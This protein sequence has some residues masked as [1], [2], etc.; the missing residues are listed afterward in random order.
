VVEGGTVT[1]PDG[2][3]LDGITRQSAIDLLGELNVKLVKGD[4]CPARLRQAD[5]AFI[6]STA[7]GI[8]PVTKVDHAPIADGEA[9][10]LSLRLRELYWQRHAQG[11]H[12]E[13]VDYEP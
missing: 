2:T 6:T 13:P 11:W 12:G 10:P 4:V 9:G 8:L 1:T 7:G 3:C 5:E